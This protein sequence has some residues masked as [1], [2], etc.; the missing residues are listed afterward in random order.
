[1]SY[2]V[3]Q[4]KSKFLDDQIRQAEWRVQKHQQ[5]V[6]LRTTTLVQK[7]YQQLTDPASLLLAGGIGFILG[8]V[9]KRQTSK[10]RATDGKDKARSTETSPL[11]VVLNL[12]TSA[13]TIYTALPI[14]WMLKSHFQRPDAATEGADARLQSSV[15]VSGPARNRRRS[16]V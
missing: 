5:M 8:E 4:S 9:T 14:V 1:M 12:M 13:Q 16:G 7:I 10:P 11:K 2:P 15:P 3:N 6:D